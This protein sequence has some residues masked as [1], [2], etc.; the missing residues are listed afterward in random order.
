[1][2]YVGF[3]SFEFSNV[4][5]GWIRF[6]WFSWGIGWAGLHFCDLCCLDMFGGD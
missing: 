3:V 2:G 4:G 6:T 1:M 5:L